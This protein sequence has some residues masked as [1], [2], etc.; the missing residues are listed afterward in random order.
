MVTS[1]HIPT[2]N[3]NSPPPPPK[4][5]LSPAPRTHPPPLY[6]LPAILTSAQEAFLSQRKAEVCDRT[7]D[8][9]L[10]CWPIL[11]Q[12]KEAA[13]KEW[14]K[15]KEE[16]AIGV[17]E[18]KELRQHVA[19]EQERRKAER[20]SRG[21]IE[22]DKEMTTVNDSPIAEKAKDGMDIDDA[23]AGSAT[24]EESKDAV[25]EPDVKDESVAMQADDD[26]AV[27]Y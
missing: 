11:L 26:D 2:A 18:I 15:F 19:E 22:V 7:I 24:K 3:D 5:I 20:E 27:E 4:N 9:F 8:I 14:E 16:R 21:E 13:E 10:Y 17:E 25:A 1:D 23:P 6:Y 12:V